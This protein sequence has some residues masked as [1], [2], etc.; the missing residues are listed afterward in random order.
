ML[1]NPTYQTDSLQK[2][3][4]K[5]LLAKADSLV[6]K[7][8]SCP[9]IKLSNLQNL[10]LDGVETGLLLLNIAQQLHRKNADVP[11]N[12]LNSVDAAG[13]SPNLVLNQIAKSKQSGS[14]IP[15]KM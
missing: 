11:D 6:D 9:L 4:N 2:E 3:I 14:W 5:K 15:F 10:V 1:Q 12:Y 7:I 13:I 8:F